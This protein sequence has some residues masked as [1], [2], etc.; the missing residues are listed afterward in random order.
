MLN[1]DTATT[2]NDIQDQ[3]DEVDSLLDTQI[4]FLVDNVGEAQRYKLKR[5]NKINKNILTGTIEICGNDEEG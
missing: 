1:I 4:D 5:I 2:P 3:V